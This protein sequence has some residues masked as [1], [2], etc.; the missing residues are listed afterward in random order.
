MINIMDAVN[1][2][3]PDI[4]VTIRH[5]KQETYLDKDGNEALTST[6]IENFTMEFQEGSPTVTREEIVV[7]Y[8]RQ[9]AIEPQTRL[10]EERVLKL[11][12]SDWTVL[13]D[14][15]LSSAKKTKWETYRQELRDL[16]S[17]QSPTIDTNDDGFETLKN[18]TWP[19]E[20]S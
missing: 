20:P 1:T 2:L 10:R 3:N 5:Q 11:K 7:E 9:V 16:P 13:P 19:T 14:S 6:P 8:E 12:D 15:A 17:T 18:V 4:K